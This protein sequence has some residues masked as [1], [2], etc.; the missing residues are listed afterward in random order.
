M[1]PN[2]VRTQASFSKPVNHG[3]MPGL[4]VL[5]LSIS[6]QYQFCLGVHLHSY[7]MAAGELQSLIDG[8]I[9]HLGSGT[10]RPRFVNE[11][12]KDYERNTSAALLLTTRQVCWNGLQTSFGSSD[13]WHGK[14]VVGMC[15]C[16]YWRAII[17]A[18]R[19]CTLGQFKCVALWRQQHSA[20]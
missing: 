11:R 15:K 7:V 5:N 13:Y 19:I 9:A 12:D 6:V 1:I 18:Q 2:F 20:T 10:L 4:A 14:F 3:C 17:F 16:L 8:G